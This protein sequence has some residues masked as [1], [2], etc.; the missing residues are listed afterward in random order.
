MHLAFASVFGAQ[1]YTHCDE[2]CLFKYIT[3]FSLL[4]QVGHSAAVHSYVASRNSVFM[5]LWLNILNALKFLWNFISLLIHPNLEHKI[6]SL[7]KVYLAT[8][9]GAT[10]KI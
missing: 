1:R 9:I 3:I 5:T 10:Q 8:C 4:I 6:K 7:L 2:L